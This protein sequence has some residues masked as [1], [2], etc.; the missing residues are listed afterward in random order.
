MAAM[1]A[2]L[3]L[4]VGLVADEREHGLEWRREPRFIQPR[5]YAR[6]RLPAARW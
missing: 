5:L 6:E 3:G 1:L 2:Y 4:E